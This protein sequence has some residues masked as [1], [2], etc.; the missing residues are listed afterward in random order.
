[1]RGAA[2]VFFLLA[3]AARLHAAPSAADLAVWPD[4]GPYRTVGDPGLVVLKMPMQVVETIQQVM[5]DAPSQWEIVED[6]NL[7]KHGKRALFIQGKSSGLSFLF[8]RGLWI[9]PLKAGA[10]PFLDDFLPTLRVADLQ[11]EKV[12]EKYLDL[13]TYLHCYGDS[14][15]MSDDLRRDCLTEGGIG[16]WFKKEKRKSAILSL[17]HDPVVIKDNDRLSIICNFLLYHGSVERWTFHLRVGKVMQLETIDKIE[18][19]KKGTFGFPLL[20]H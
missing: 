16:N 8:T 5:P 10:V 18:L 14:L 19:R 13:V 9:N 7:S 12:L 6:T 1:M 17:C 15:I 20:T 2:L 4:Q 3:L 11:N